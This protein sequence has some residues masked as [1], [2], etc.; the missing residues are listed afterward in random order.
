MG[1]GEEH[2][3]ITKWMQELTHSNRTNCHH[4]LWNILAF[5]SR[6][7]LLNVML[8]PNSQ[9]VKDY[10]SFEPFLKILYNTKILYKLCSLLPKISVDK[11]SAL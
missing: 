10:L 8:Y 2:G 3:N 6:F 9:N 7:Y 11:D 1:G 4:I 5:S